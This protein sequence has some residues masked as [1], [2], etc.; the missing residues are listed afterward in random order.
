[1]NA[2]TDVTACL[3][4]PGLLV[5]CRSVSSWKLSWPLRA[6]RPQRE[7]SST[8]EPVPPPLALLMPQSVAEAVAL[9]EKAEADPVALEQDPLSF[10]LTVISSAPW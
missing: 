4:I 10:E 1:M 5:V 8:V 9:I 7:R 3:K 6:E 2:D